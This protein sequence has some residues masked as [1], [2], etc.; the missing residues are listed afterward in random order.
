MRY[1]ATLATAVLVTLII[2]CNTGRKSS[3]GFWLP[4]GDVE[5]GKAVFLELKCNACHLVEGLALPHPDMN[6]PVIVALGGEVYS[7]PT[8]GE[9]VTSIINPSHR[10]PPGYPKELVQKDGKSLMPDYSEE[11]TVRQMIDLVAFLHSNYEVVQ[12]QRYK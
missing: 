9:L 10:F 3:I 4:D 5:K 2:G 7:E 12:L 8:D 6:S 11:M 1:F